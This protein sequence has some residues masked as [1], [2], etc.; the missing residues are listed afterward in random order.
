MVEGGLSA[1]GIRRWLGSRS[2]VPAEINGGE[3][4]Q[5]GYMNKTMG[6]KLHSPLKFTWWLVPVTPSQPNPL[7][8]M[9]KSSANPSALEGGREGRDYT[10]AIGVLRPRKVLHMREPHGIFCRVLQ[11]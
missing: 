7:P 2:T 3:G 8:A 10:G 6:S 9:G 1:L 4:V 5:F 11:I